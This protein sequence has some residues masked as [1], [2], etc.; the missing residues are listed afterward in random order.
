MARVYKQEIIPEHTID[1]CV[2][3][4]CDLCRKEARESSNW[5][6]PEWDDEETQIE[7]RARR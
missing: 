5:T 4:T 6:S 7:I 2:G 3:T 1:R